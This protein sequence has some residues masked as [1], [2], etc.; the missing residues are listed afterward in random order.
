MMSLTTMI[1]AC[2]MAQRNIVCCG[3]YGMLVGIGVFFMAAGIALILWV[4]R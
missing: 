4:M 1:M 2:N 3:I